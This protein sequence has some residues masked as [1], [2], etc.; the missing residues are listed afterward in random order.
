MEALLEILFRKGLSVK[1]YTRIS[2][3]YVCEIASDK[4][5]WVGV[6]PHMA[7]WALSSAFTIWEKDPSNGGVE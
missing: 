7:S 4:Y 2:G 5:S 1:L 6:D 3:E